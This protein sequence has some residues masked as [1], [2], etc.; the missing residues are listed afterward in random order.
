MREDIS[1]SWFRYIDM[2]KDGQHFTSFHST[3]KETKMCRIRGL[4]SC[5][6]FDIWSQSLHSSDQAAA[7]LPGIWILAHIPPYKVASI[8]QL[9][10]TMFH[11]VSSNN[12]SNL[13][14]P[15]WSEK[16][17]LN[18]CLRKITNTIFGE[19]CSLKLQLFY[20]YMLHPGLG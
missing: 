11:L 14:K 19:K 17:N 2:K 13:L 18:I 7:Q 15:K 20:K 1:F 12:S 5:T 3:K 8:I 10:I 9:S 4:A 6:G 16:K